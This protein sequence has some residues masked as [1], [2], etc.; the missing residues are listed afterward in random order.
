[1]SASQRPTTNA[2]Q[3]SRGLQCSDC[4]TVLRT[5]YYAL[6][7]RPVCAKCREPYAER[8]QLGAGP[9][10][11]TRTLLYGVGAALI[12]AVLTGLGL[13]IFGLLRMVCAVGVGYFVG[14]AMKKAN[15]GWPGRRFQVLAVV[16]TYIALGLGSVGPTLMSLGSAR[17]ELRRAAADSVA[18]ARARAAADSD[19]ADDAASA[20]PAADLGKLADSLE[21]ARSRPRVRSSPEL[22]NAKKLAGGGVVHMLGGALLLMLILPILGLLQYGIYPAAVGLLAFG[23][24]MKKAWDLTEGGIELALSGPFRVGEGPIPPTF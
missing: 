10:A 9:G 1:M 14:S 13:R 11:M 8:I 17:Q 22:D 18:A 15:G 6:N 4:K 2:P 12:G 21:A 16:L 3:R 23:F 24:G 5:H 20:V 19:D 7:E